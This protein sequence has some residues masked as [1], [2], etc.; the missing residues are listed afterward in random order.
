[1]S[2]YDINIELVRG[3]PIKENKFMISH[4]EL[5]QYYIIATKSKK[6][7]RNKQ[8]IEKLMQRHVTLKKHQEVVGIVSN[9]LW[10]PTSAQ[11]GGRGSLM[12]IKARS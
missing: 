11:Q 4:Q 7:K 8:W 12:L 1:M 2:D 5:L 6:K 10:L 9:H 3:T